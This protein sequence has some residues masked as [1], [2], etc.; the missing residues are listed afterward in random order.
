MIR[1]LSVL[2]F[3]LVVAHARHQTLMMSV[4]R[5]AMDKNVEHVLAR[6]GNIFD[7][8]ET[9][10]EGLGLD[11]QKE[12]EPQKSGSQDQNGGI[13]A[14]L[15]N[16]IVQFVRNI[17]M[18]VTTLI[19]QLLGGKSFMSDAFGPAQQAIQQFKHM[20]APQR[21]NLRILA[22]HTLTAFDSTLK[23]RLSKLNAHD[24][25][26]LKNVKTL[27]DQPH[28]SN[29]QFAKK[30]YRKAPKLSAVVAESYKK[31]AA[32][33]HQHFSKM[34]RSSKAGFNKIITNLKKSQLRVASALNS[35]NAK[36]SLGNSL[37]LV[38]N[39]Y[40]LSHAVL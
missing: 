28:A 10:D 15:F 30:L 6:W 11:D 17:L 8:K 39:V 38:K 18:S 16:A 33:F 12:P 35:G 22:A 4:A 25:S 7:G 29:A 20:S 13:V 34:D 40:S 37:H 1:S 2:F 21:K 9:G 32:V 14:N 5:A 19:S 27:L 23:Q 24:A 26:E 31:A 3:F 36:K